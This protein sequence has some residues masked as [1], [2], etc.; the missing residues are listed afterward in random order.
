MSI[1]IIT[2]PSGSGKTTIANI[3]QE[4][5]TLLQKVVTHTTRPM[6]PGEIDGVHYHFVSEGR[7]FL[8]SDNG[9][10]IESAK[11][12]GSYYGS[13]SKELVNIEKAGK[14]PLIVT[15]VQGAQWWQDN[16]PEDA[17][18]LFLLPP[19][20]DELLSRL[21]DRGSKETIQLR[22]GQVMDETVQYASQADYIAL[23]DNVESTVMGVLEFISS[24]IR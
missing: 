8:L 16:F 17:I 14:H 3:L 7:F 2:G 21:E 15:D 20:Q 1:F 24:K 23:N 11:V 5:C 10:F 4:R 18:T 9:A 19:T 6:R 22:M 13:S 12:Y